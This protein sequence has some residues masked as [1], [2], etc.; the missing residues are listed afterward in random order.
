MNNEK[1]DYEKTLHL[2]L[3]R[4]ALMSNLWTQMDSVPQEVADAVREIGRASL[5]AQV[6][7]RGAVKG[8]SH[9]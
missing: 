5:L 1:Q 7:L 8:T 9:E 3:E 4:T 6:V 2:F